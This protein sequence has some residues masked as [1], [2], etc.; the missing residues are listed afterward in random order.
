MKDCMF[1]FSEGHCK[2]LKTQKCEHCK[3]RKTEQQYIDGQKHA[4][5]SLK[6]KGLKKQVVSNGEQSYVTVR[7]LKKALKKG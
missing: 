7:P 5:E 1:Y 3:F 4:D 2:I 6:H